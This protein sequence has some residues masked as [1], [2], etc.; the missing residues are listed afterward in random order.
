LSAKNLRGAKGN[1]AARITSEWIRRFSSIA[2]H[3]NRSEAKVALLSAFV[4]SGSSIV[5]IAEAAI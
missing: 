1:V 5:I 4:A 3:S 2:S